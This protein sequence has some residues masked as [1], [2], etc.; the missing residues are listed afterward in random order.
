MSVFDPTP[1]EVFERVWEGRRNVY[2]TRGFDIADFD[3]VHI[4]VSHKIYAKIMMD[5]RDKSA[6]YRHLTPVTYEAD[7]IAG[8]EPIEWRMKMFGVPVAPSED[9]E[10]HEVRFRVEVAV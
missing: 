7:N 10:P 1:D 5:F 4:V 8:E 6:V 2:A 3:S 9:L